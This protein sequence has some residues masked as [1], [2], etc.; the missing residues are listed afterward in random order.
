V[1]HERATLMI[2]MTMVAAVVSLAPAPA[3]SQPLPTPDT[4]WNPSLTPDGQPDIGG[5][6]SQ[7]NGIT[8]YS[9]QAGDS[10]RTEH[11][12]I[13]GQE[14]ATGRPIV[15]PPDGRIPYQPW[16]A[17]RAQFLYDEH[18]HPSLETLDPVSRSFLDGVPRINYRGTM[19]IVQ[20]PG[21]VVIINEYN[22]TYRVIPIDGS[23][24]I[25]AAVKLWMGDSR[26]HWEGN[27]LVVDV[28]NHNEHTWFDIVGSFHSDALHV[29][30]RWTFVSPDR[31]DYEATMEDSKVFARPWKLLVNM[32]R[33]ED[34]E[35]WESAIWEGNHLVE[36]ILGAPPDV[37]RSP[38]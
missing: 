15:D 18:R 6:W 12:G 19:R 5:H 9:I 2:A 10:D 29:V 20:T 26:G 7:E 16:A 30:E 25:G 27:T 8:T 3:V 23:P 24:H 13:T 14:V 38:W 21:Q 22:H 1:R 35:I 32:G 11:I 4:P 31:I 28:T 37:K 34:Y 17:E 33:V 36:N